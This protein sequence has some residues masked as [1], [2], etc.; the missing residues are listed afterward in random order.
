VNSAT[1]EAAS[2]S[3]QAVFSTG[4][5]RRKD[6]AEATPP[7]MMAHGIGLVSTPLSALR[8]ASNTAVRPLPSA[9]SSRDSAMHSELVITMST[10]IVRITVPAADGPSS[11]TISGTPMKPELGNAATSAPSEASFQRIRSLSEMTIAKA[12]TVS[13]HSRYSAAARTSSSC[14][15]GVVEPKRNNMHGSAKYRTKPFSPGMASSGNSRRRAA[16]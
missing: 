4:P 3:S 1:G 9:S 10:T 8:A 5:G 7:R 13:P 6:H 14:A 16:T 11:A 2:A 12:T 15:I